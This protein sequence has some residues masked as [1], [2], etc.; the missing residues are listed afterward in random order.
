MPDCTQYSVKIIS[1]T[2]NTNFE[3]IFLAA[4]RP[5]VVTYDTSNTPFDPTRYSRASINVVA[6]EK[7][8][9]VFSED[10]QGTR[11]ILTNEDTGD[12]KWVGYLTSNL[13][14][15]PDASC[16]AETF[17]LEANDCISTLDKYDYQGW[18]SA[19]T[20]VTFSQLLA[21]IANRCGQITD[22]FV[23]MS[24]LRGNGTYI[25][26]DDLSISEQN[27][28]SSDTDEPW[29]V[30]EVLVE[31]CKY[32]GYTAMQIGTSLYLVDLQAHTNQKWNGDT[33][34]LYY[35]FYHYTKATN[36]GTFV[37]EAVNV[38][39]ITLR[40]SIMMGTG[41]DISLETLYNKIQVKDSFYEIDHFIPDIYDDT[42][43]K[44]REGDFWKCNQIAPPGLHLN[45]M[46]KNG[47][48][49]SEEKAENE[50]VYYIR[51]FDHNNY[52]YIYRDVDT[53]QEVEVS[54]FTASGISVTN[55]EANTGSSGA[56]GQFYDL[57]ANFYNND[58]VAHNISVYVAVG[59][60]WYQPPFASLMSDEGVKTYTFTIQPHSE[61]V[62]AFS[63]ACGS[64]DIIVALEYRNHMNIDGGPDVEIQGGYSS[65][66]MK[67]VSS[68]IVD[69][70]TFDKPMDIDKY[71]YETE[72]DISFE[73]YI[74]IH[75]HDQPYRMHPYSMWLF[76]DA[77]EPLDDDQIE[78]VFPEI[79]RL[80]SGYTNP[81]IIN[82]K[83]YLSIN[84]KAI[85][86]RYEVEYINPD[87]TK[88]NT[89]RSFLGLLGPVHGITTMAPCLIF[90][91]KIGD[92][93]WSPDA[94]LY[95][96]GWT[97]TECCFV[98]DLGTDKTDKD[99][100]D[101]TAWWNK[102]HPVLNNISWTD[103]AGLSGYKIPLDETLD[104]S[105]PI[106][107]SMMMPS[108]MQ[109]ID[110]DYTLQYNEMCW[111]K[112]LSIEFTTKDSENYDN[113][114]VLYENIINSGSVNTLSDV[115]CRFTTYPGDG[116]HSYSSV[117]LD[118]ALANQMVRL[119][120]DNIPNKAEENIIKAY[121]N[122]YSS[123]TIKENLTINLDANQLSR[124]YDPTITRYFNILGGEIDYGAGSQRLTIV[125]SKMWDEKDLT[126]I[127]LTA[128]WARDIP[129]TGGTATSGNCNVS[130]MAHYDDG[131]SEE[132]TSATTITGS[133][134]VPSSTTETRHSAGTLTLT[135]EY[136]NKS[137]ST[138]VVVYQ[139]AYNPEPTYVVVQD[140]LDEG[141]ARVVPG[142]HG[143]YIEILSGCPY[144]STTYVTDLWEVA[145]NEKQLSAGTNNVIVWTQPLPSGWETEMELMYRQYRVDDGYTLNFTPRGGLL[146][147]LGSVIFDDP[148][149]D[150]IPNSSFTITFSGGSWVEADYPWGSYGLPE[151]VFAPRYKEGMMNYYAGNGFFNTP[152]KV[153][154]NFN[155][156]YSSIGQVMFTN[157]QTTTQFYM[158]GDRKF[159]CHDVTGMFEG[160]TNL[161]TLSLEALDWSTIRTCHN[162]FDGCDNL[163]EIFGGAKTWW[164]Y[165]SENYAP[166][167]LFPHFDGTRGSA[168]CS[169]L[170]DCP[171]LDRCQFFKINME[172][173]SLSG[174][175]YNGMQQAP[176][177]GPMIYAPNC[178]MLYM[179]N[180]NNNDWDFT[181][182][183]SYIYLPNLKKESVAYLLSHVKNVAGLG[184]CT[185][186]LSH[187]C[188][189]NYTAVDG[190]AVIS[191]DDPIYSSY[192]VAQARGWN[193]LFKILSTP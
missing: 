129:D 22:L 79:M 75:T 39:G 147:A 8:F 138:S 120:L 66:E 119:G 158:P 165:D 142:P 183:D 54:G 152:G 43:L 182:P 86:E 184:G 155:G 91:L 23:D 78:A 171:S 4:E 144:A 166:Y 186:V 146:W 40:Q 30:Q 130:V 134:V 102:E 50:H 45:Y 115:S 108:K 181:D 81:M 58:E 15:M 68:C 137:A 27:F 169:H 151:G 90:K 133:L 16:G 110:G 18:T 10:A 126:R 103:W 96:N 92:K 53:L 109:K 188:L 185:L 38:D 31:L 24:L 82:D 19:K 117:G 121:S 26:M 12:V 178:R 131:T 42:L 163:Y 148:T 193:V 123:P 177:D 28:Y 49:K 29:N 7:F 88:E 124:I 140:L 56:T 63:A 85:F 72:S 51:K 21:G 60:A 77:M 106:E 112:D 136:M 122:Q 94:Y 168:N 145:K 25:T 176:L 3:E 173:I 164:R 61:Y 167:T 84:A 143:N 59:C 175:T 69:L 179:D 135:A 20:I 97:T 62:G 44:N 71:L 111:I 2:G 125:Q 174:M 47:N 67:Y 6:D 189:T 139:K 101:F 116:M 76:E 180:L 34:T 14:N 36:W 74:M 87:W 157:M 57:H 89:R 105:Q 13:L 132:V 5:F 93:Y 80:S 100:V 113:A 160:C 153:V 156:T 64:G 17:S 55:V 46:G 52:E 190:Y 187:N 98:V 159:F 65:L 107:F 32:L 11:V 172:A 73:R 48:V 149:I 114:D 33:D 35:N 83:A 161:E 99:D 1:D 41:A 9:D 192:Q 170:L 70:A 154:V 150:P 104:F 118:N 141:W 162:M 191:S 37:Q 127:E 95:S 128:T